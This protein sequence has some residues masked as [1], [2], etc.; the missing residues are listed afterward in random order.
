MKLAAIALLL[1]A[2]LV[3]TVSATS[4]AL[5]TRTVSYANQR[6]LSCEMT[7]NEGVRLLRN[8]VDSHRID[9]WQDHNPMHIRVTGLQ[10]ALVERIPGV[11][12]ENYIADLEAAVVAHEAELAAIAAAPTAGWFDAYHPVDDILAY[13]KNLT[14]TYPSL[15]SWV[16]SIGKSTLGKDI[17]AVHVTSAKGSNKPKFFIQCNIHAREWISSAVCNYLIDFLV[18]NYNVN[19]TVAAILDSQELVVIPVLNVDGLA[20]TYSN[21]RL[22]RKNLS[23]NKGSKCLGTDLNRNYPYH[24]NNGGSS[25]NPC[26][27][28][29]MGTA[30][31][32]EPETQASVNYFRASAPA[33]AAID[34]HS[35]SQLVLRPWGDTNTNCQDETRFAKLGTNMVNTIYALTKT[36]YTSEKSIG[37]YPTSGTASDFFYADDSNNKGYRAA[38]YTIELRDT[39]KQGFLLSPTQIVPNGEEILGAFLGFATDIGANPIVNA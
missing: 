6:V 32:S 10:A 13:Y 28:T 5:P 8:F 4:S 36:T 25:S 35:Y 16:P 14:V 2:C 39:G 29:Y 21:D 18:K 26:D 20:Y 27:D 33:I 30:A 34:F 38:S 3:A 9:I 7:S 24:W 23:T 1:S 37:L 19:S 12:C 11:V 31:N 15:I 22:W 17:P